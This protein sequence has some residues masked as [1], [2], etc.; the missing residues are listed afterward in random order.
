MK[1]T[2]VVVACLVLSL[3]CISGD[4]LAVGVWDIG[5]TIVGVSPNGDWQSGD[6]V[7]IKLATT[8]A[9]GCQIIRFKPGFGHLPDDFN[10]EAARNRIYAAALAALLSQKQ[11]SVWVYDT[12]DCYGLMLTIG[13][14]GPF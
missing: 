14:T 2:L 12:T 1:K 13:D 3:V 6:E 5:V 7:R 4:A 11:V 10:G 9:S 8:G